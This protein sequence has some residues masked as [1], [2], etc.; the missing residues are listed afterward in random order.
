MWVALCLGGDARLW[1]KAFA[2]GS[3][4][5]RGSAWERRAL[6]ERQEAGISWSPAVHHVSLP[7][8]VSPVSS[9]VVDEL[10]HVSYCS[11]ASCLPCLRQEFGETGG[12][13][14][15][16][17]LPSRLRWELGLIHMANPILLGLPRVGRGCPLTGRAG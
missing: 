15:P 13:E 7:P 3:L 8:L 9:G 6:G 1:P 12:T 14:P 5:L 11:A 4:H 16:C 2:A 10:F 17:Q